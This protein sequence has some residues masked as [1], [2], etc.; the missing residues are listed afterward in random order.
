MLFDERGHRFVIRLGLG[1]AQQ[2]QAHADLGADAEQAGPHQ[3]QDL[4]RHHHHQTIGQR[5]QPPALAQKL[6]CGGDGLLRIGD[7]VQRLAALWAMMAE[8][9][10]GLA[11]RL[12]RY[13]APA[14]LLRR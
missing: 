10:P 4:G 8:L 13:A 9:D 5:D 14:D 6:G 11:E 12:P 3:R 2:F 1:R 7:V